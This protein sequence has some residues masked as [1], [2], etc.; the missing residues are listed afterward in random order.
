MGLKNHASRRQSLSGLSSS[1]IALATLQLAGAGIVQG[2]CGPV[3]A[4]VAVDIGH[5]PRT[6]GAMSATGKPEYLFNKRFVEELAALR[7][8]K[9]PIVFQAING[10]GQEMSLRERPRAA[11]SKGSIVLFSVHHDS[12]QDKYLI[13]WEHEGKLRYYTEKARGYSLF[14]SSKNARFG[15]SLTLAQLI[16]EGLAAEN[17]AGSHHH[18]ERIR[19]EGRKL[20][21]P[22]ANVYDAPFSVLVHSRIP[23]VL[24]E[25]AVITNKE[26]EALAENRQSRERMQHTIARAFEVYCGM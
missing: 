8:K 22:T 17:F 14:V 3:P 11:V 6:P 12:V 16:G 13:P 15:E 21:L 7:G 2:S 18:S 9:Y 5:S 20:L 10:D 4:I 25:V 19:G 1:V 24:L 26:D 23:A